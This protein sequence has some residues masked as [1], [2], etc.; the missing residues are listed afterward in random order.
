MHKCGTWTQQLRRTIYQRCTH[1]KEWPQNTHQFEWQNGS[2][3][4]QFLQAHTSAQALTN[5]VWLKRPSPLVDK[6]HG[7]FPWLSTIADQHVWC[8]PCN[9]AKSSERY[10]T[11]ESDREIICLVTCSITPEPQKKRGGKKNKTRPQQKCAVHCDKMNALRLALAD[12]GF[13]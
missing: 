6:H 11:L 8:N 4:I 13:G 1:V 10:R 5:R 3:P 9:N 2:G 12:V 7:R